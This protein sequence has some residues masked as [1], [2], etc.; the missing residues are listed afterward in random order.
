MVSVADANSGEKERECDET[1]R[2]T[3]SPDG[4]IRGEV[5]AVPAGRANPGGGGG[6]GGPFFEEGGGGPL[7]DKRGGAPPDP[8]PVPGDPRRRRGG[9]ARAAHRH[10]PGGG[11]GDASHGS[12][13]HPVSARKV[14]LPLSFPLVARGRGRGRGGGGGSL[15]PGG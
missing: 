4:R 11:Q 6:R 7:P 3:R 9:T 5:V 10:R 1:P 8:G 2:W 15:P 13:V 14:L 12:R